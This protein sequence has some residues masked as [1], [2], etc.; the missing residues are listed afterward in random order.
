[1]A[2]KNQTLLTKNFQ[3]TDD[4]SLKIDSTKE[5]TGSL[6]PE[7]VIALCGPIGSPL[8]ETADRIR[9]SLN[10]FGYLSINVR[11]SDLIR[12]NAKQVQTTIDESTK[13]LEIKSLIN[14]GDELRSNH[15]NDVLAKLAI[16]KIS[17][18]RTK[19]YE[20]FDDHANEFQK[21]VKHF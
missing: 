10:S 16:A 2:A 1:M 5:V 12:L 15:G 20:E 4:A 3:E 7:L 17:A 13:Y 6:T 19:T 21:N 11:L 14:A 8:H 9:H 18:D